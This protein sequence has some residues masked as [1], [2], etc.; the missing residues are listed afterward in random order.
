MSCLQKQ[1]IQVKQIIMLETE[2][3][4]IHFLILQ[5]NKLVH[6]Q[7]ITDYRYIGYYGANQKNYVTLT[8][9]CGEC[10]EYLL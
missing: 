8:L 7:T 5:Q 4:C 10:L 3:K 9:K 6:L 2:R 1:M